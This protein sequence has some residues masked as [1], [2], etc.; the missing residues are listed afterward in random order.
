MRRNEGFTLVELLVAVF[1]FSVGIVGVLALFVGA[2]QSS[3]IAAEETEAALVAHSIVAELRSEV[4][5]G[6]KITNVIN[7]RHPDFPK[8]HYSVDAVALDKTGREFFV[9]ITIT[10]KRRSR[11]Y[12]EKFRT[13][14]VR[15]Q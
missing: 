6:R 15:K 14:I 4:E 3:R 2:A 8:F 5:A 11:A 1:I 10:V 13:I 9:E 12:N 7:V